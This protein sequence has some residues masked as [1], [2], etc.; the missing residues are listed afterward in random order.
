MARWSN[1]AS[2]LWQVASR[3][4]WRARGIDRLAEDA[5][6]RGWDDVARRLLAIFTQVAGGA[7]GAPATLP[8]PAPTPAI[9]NLRE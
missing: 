5:A 1:A 8:A 2:R 4:R 3:L 9:A 7:P 6:Q